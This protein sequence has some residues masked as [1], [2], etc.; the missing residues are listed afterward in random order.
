[1]AAKEPLDALADAAAVAV[2]IAGFTWFRT[3]K[4]AAKT[5]HPI[6]PTPAPSAGTGPE[7]P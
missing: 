5:L 3:T 4:T 6:D 7:T 1:M 2:L